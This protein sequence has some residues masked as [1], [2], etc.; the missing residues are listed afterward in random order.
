MLGQ[1]LELLF[2]SKGQMRQC[3]MVVLAFSF[4]ASV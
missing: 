3:F 4:I 1:N 2:K